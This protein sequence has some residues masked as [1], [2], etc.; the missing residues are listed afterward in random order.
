MDVI[1]LRT[2]VAIARAKDDEELV[3]L[4]DRID[5]EFVQKGKTGVESGEGFLTYDENGKLKER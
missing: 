3:A 5:E 1:G 4:G 2:M